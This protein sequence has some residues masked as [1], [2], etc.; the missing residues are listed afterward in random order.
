MQA[1][2]AAASLDIEY[3]EE[4]FC[5]LMK[6][7]DNTCD[8]YKP[9]ESDDLPSALTSFVSLDPL[10]LPSPLSPTRTETTDAGQNMLSS[11]NPKP[12][13]PSPRRNPMP[14]TPNPK[15]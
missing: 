8:W 5:A 1:H 2:A 14:Q 7:L 10:S 15:P 13:A 3:T 12:E 9:I 6:A 4:A 11:L